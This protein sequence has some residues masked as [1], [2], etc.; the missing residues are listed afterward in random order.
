MRIKTEVKDG[1]L[2]SRNILWLIFKY[3]SNLYIRTHPNK[4]L[5]NAIKYNIILPTSYK[6]DNYL[7]KS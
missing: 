2:A 3:E 4:L 6:I 5:C 7:V 1:W